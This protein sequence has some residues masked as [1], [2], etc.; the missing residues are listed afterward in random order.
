[1]ILGINKI[2][3]LESGVTSS[4]LKTKSIKI[5]TYSQDVTYT[6]DYYLNESAFNQGLSPIETKDYIVDSGFVRQ[7]LDAKQ[8]DFGSFMYSLL[9]TVI[10]GIL[11]ND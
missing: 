1:M 4:F 9:N 3:V 7:F 10:E 8:L 11:V 5:D 6:L 2:T